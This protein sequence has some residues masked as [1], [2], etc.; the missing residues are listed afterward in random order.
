MTGYWELHGK[1]SPGLLIKR[2]K[3]MER[4]CVVLLTLE[5][6]HILISFIFATLSE[7]E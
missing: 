3:D 2:A 4:V 7:M 6:N 1:D 5:S